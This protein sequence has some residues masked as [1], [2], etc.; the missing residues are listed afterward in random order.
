MCARNAVALDQRGLESRDKFVTRQVT[1]RTTAGR[2]RAR[3]SSLSAWRVQR[4]Y[5][6]FT[7]G[8]SLTAL[9]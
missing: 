6:P 8:W 7:P 5:Q 2:R 9:N 4:A 3:S 1:E